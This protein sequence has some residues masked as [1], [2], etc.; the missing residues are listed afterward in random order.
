[1]AVITQRPTARPIAGATTMKTSVLVQPAGMMATQPALATAA[2]A[3]PPKS[4]PAHFLAHGDE[5]VVEALLARDEPETRHHPL[6]SAGSA[7]AQS[8]KRGRCRS[9]G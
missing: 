4:A 9:N 5:L 8:N 3:Q 7:G 1:M 6:P 2:P